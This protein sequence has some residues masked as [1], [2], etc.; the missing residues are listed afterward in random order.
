[1]SND[2]QAAAERL[3]RLYNANDS[4]AEVYGVEQTGAGL[5]QR[6]EQAVVA[7]YLALHDP[8]PLDE[9]WLKAVG[10]KRVRTTGDV[11]AYRTGP[12]HASLHVVSGYGGKDW[13]AMVVKFPADIQSD[14]GKY[15][16]FDKRL[17]T[18]GDVR[19]LC[20]ALG[21]DLTD[22]RTP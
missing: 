4:Y 1:M 14:A 21:I 22:E 19:R 11:S 10:F 9:A 16:H 18:R 6:D 17:S 5:Q 3:R 15:P 20:A 8:T 12:Q 2:V 13:W 7:A